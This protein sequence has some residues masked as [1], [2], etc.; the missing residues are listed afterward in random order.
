MKQITE[1][2]F[3]KLP[4]NEQSFRWALFV[5]SEGYKK[6]LSKKKIKE[7]A[8]KYKVVLK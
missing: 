5:E 8:D 3:E 2:E 1:K 4:M 6:E 7:I